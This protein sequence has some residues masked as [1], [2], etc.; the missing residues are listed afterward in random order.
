MLDLVSGRSSYLGTR[1]EL[2]RLDASGDG[3]L[4]RIL[5]RATR[6]SAEQ[7]DVARVGIWFFDEARESLS[8]T[9]LY[10]RESE[11]HSKPG[12]TLPA[13][14]SRAY[15][16]AI[17]E[18]RVLAVSH[19]R[20]HPATRDLAACYLDPNRIASMLDAPIFRHG[21]V[22]GVV[23]HE[24][25][26]TP[27]TWPAREMDFAASV[28]DM[29][30]LYCEE[31]AALVSER[32]LR[33][34]EAELA[35]AERLAS[36]GVVARHIAHD[37]NNAVAP[38][39]MCG[40]KLRTLVAGDPRLLEHVT[41]IVNAAEHGASLARRLLVS[42]VDRAEPLE[43]TLVDPLLADA[44]PLFAT[45]LSEGQTLRLEQGA[46][47]AGVRM[48]PIELVRSLINLVNNARD[49]TPGP[50]EVAIRSEH[51]AGEVL[52]RVADQ[53]T[54]MSEAVQNRLFQPFFTTKPG[55]GYGLGLSGVRASVERAQGRVEVQTGP[56]GTTVTLS[57]PAA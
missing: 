23:C 54:G 26:G 18:R 5:E 20:E 53:G 40:Q 9:L 57:L 48:D 17:E 30:A 41:I 2:A 1:L 8:Q 52:I 22:V 50:G 24:H 21:V 36:V 31:A 38:I 10:E 12:L 46:P 27:R 32:R 13:Q 51:V 47:G 14:A 11:R 29:V 44:R 6:L 16:A 34:Q 43:P 25:V 3:R 4:E 15:L 19:V 7:L 37:L 56:A 45:L 28:A 49:A 55:R 39:L 33:A 35:K 42:P